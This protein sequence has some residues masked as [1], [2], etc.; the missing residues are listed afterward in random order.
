MMEHGDAIFDLS[1]FMQSV[2]NHSISEQSH[3]AFKDGRSAQ[4]GGHVAGPSGFEVRFADRSQ[5]RALNVGHA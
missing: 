3:P 5:A 1:L 2:T 4:D